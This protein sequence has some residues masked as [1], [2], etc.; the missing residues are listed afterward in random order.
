MFPFYNEEQ[1]PAVAEYCEENL[2]TWCSEIGEYL[3]MWFGYPSA[4]RYA[5]CIFIL[6]G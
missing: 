6:S 2:E 4:E 3:A 5:K 1:V